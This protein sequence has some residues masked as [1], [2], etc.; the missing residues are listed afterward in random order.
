MKAIAGVFVVGVFV[1]GLAVWVR[2]VPPV[3]AHVD[4]TA[5][6]RADFDAYAAVFSGSD[7]ALRISRQE[8]LV[9]LINQILVKEEAARRGLGV[10]DEDLAV[11]LGSMDADAAGLPKGLSR[12]LT[13]DV[14]FR[15]RMRLFL[16]FQLVKAETVGAPDIALVDLRAAYDADPSLHVISFAEAAPTL[17]DRLSQ[18]ESDRRWSQ[19]L[20]AQR[21]C[22]DIRVEDRS[23][24]IPLPTPRSPC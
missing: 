9:S 23:F 1:L 14:G 4:G 11:A 13:G 22:A 10:N 8:V 6:T 15:E 24:D 2:Q 21:A 7:G 12:D 3:V 5:I 16:L 20:A 17:K 18:V 19:W